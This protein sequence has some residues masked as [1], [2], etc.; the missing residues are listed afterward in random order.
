M[1]YPQTVTEVDRKPTQTMKAMVQESYGP[2][3]EV[4]EM[5][6][7]PR[8]NPADHEVLIR[9]RASSVNAMEW[10]LMSGV[11]ILLR[12]AF[13]V[14]R[15]DNRVAGADVAGVVEA[16]GKG[17]TR[18]QPG[19]AVF[20]EIHSGAYAEYAVAAESLLSHKPETVSFED[21]AAVG[22]AGLTALQF[23]RDI[24]RVR[25]GQRVLING[26]AGGVGTYAIQIAKVLGAEV[27]GVCS[28]RNIDQ[29]LDLGA[30]HVVDY[31]VA[32]PLETDERYDVVLDMAGTRSLLATKRVMTPNG[33]YCM[34]GG[35]KNRWVGPIPRLVWG[36]LNFMFSSR[37]QKVYTAVSKSEDLAYL[38]ELL[39][40]G[41]IRSVIEARYPLE[42]LTT[43]L[44]RQGSFHSRGKTVIEI[45]NSQE[46]A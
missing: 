27:T 43:P 4:V 37:S 35:S 9:V 13:G 34:V 38:G 28:T 14:R 31:T 11:P 32:N 41:A 29:A 3:S 21:A 25:P 45:H 1:S 40:S 36:T 42:E 19:D 23:L 18:F 6:E 12:P 26:A 10:H 44:E 2:L 15:P 30:D 46:V 17:V 5:A 8:P 22:V 7:L 33:V 20:G 16:A 24:A 39:E